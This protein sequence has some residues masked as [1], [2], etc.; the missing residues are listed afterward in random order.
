M[1]DVMT[2]KEAAALHGVT[3]TAIN[4]RMRKHGCAPCGKRGRT[5]LWLRADVERV[6]A[7]CSEAPRRWYSALEVA[8]VAYIDPA[9]VHRTMRYGHRVMVSRVTGRRCRH[10]TAKT[11]RKHF[12]VDMTQETTR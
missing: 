9:V 3:L 7:L 12:G 4:S 1:S 8:D 11:I 6:L 10:W 2:T 5:A